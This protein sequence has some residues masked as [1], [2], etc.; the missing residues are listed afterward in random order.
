MAEAQFTANLTDFGRLLRRAGI[1]VDSARLALAAQAFLVVGVADRSDVAAALEAVLVAR[2]DDRLHFRALFDQF[3][4]PPLRV[5]DSL[6]LAAQTSARND[7]PAGALGRLA[8]APALPPRGTQRSARPQPHAQAVLASA[9]ASMR[10]ADFNVLSDSEFHDVQ[11]MAGALRLP[12]PDYLTRRTQPGARGARL[13]WPG[14]MGEA[15]RHAGEWMRLPHLRRTRQP[16]PVLVLVDVSGSMERYARMLLAFLHGATRGLRQRAVFAFGTE[17]TDLAPATR[18]TDPDAMLARCSRLI[19]DFA[20]GTRLGASLATLRQ[21]H[22]RRLVGR[23]TVVLLISDGLDTGDPVQLARELAWVRRHC[24]R[25][26]W[27]NPLLR[28]E[29]YAPSARG[30]RVLQEHVHA[31]V[32]VH[33]IELLENLAARLA[34]LLR[35]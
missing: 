29:A 13:H 12:V 34:A 27:L 35:R 19:A 11:R 28:Y 22:A 25:L 16:L 32:P 15:V 20:G 31:M 3:F 17:L 26:L 1:P 18:L 4:G 8:N 21:H 7:E 33:N 10:H 9:Q 23:R 2:A 14:V 30:A 6:A 5:V 24:A